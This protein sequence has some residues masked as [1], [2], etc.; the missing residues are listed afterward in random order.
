MTIFDGCRH[1]FSSPWRPSFRPFACVRIDAFDHHYEVR[2][3]SRDFGFP[4]PFA[5]VGKVDI[6]TL[7]FEVVDNQTT[8]LHMEDLH[9]SAG[10][11]DEDE[12][13]T[14]LNIASHLIG[15]DATERI[16]ALS[17]VRRMRVQVKAVAVT[18]AEHLLSRQHDQ[19]AD[20]I[21]RD[22]PA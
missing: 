19:S 16:E 17:H 18:K 20:G 3:V 12:C 1:L 14:V 11:V 9:R 8:A 5:Y 13:V 21:H 10:F 4:L 7:Q 22:T 2:P 6:A 15:H